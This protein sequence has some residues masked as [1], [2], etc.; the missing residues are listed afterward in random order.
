MFLEHQVWTIRY[1][2]I[3]TEYVK[4]WFLL[5]IWAWWSGMRSE[6]P[7]SSWSR[8][9]NVSVHMFLVHMRM[10]VIE[11]QA[12]RN[13]RISSLSGIISRPIWTD[14]P[15]SLISRLWYSIARN[16]QDPDISR[17]TDRISI[18]K[19][20]KVGKSVSVKFKKNL[21]IRIRT[22]YPSSQ[23]MRSEKKSVTQNLHVRKNLIFIC[24]L[25]S[26]QLL[27][28]NYCMAKCLIVQ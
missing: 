1:C 15:N 4:Y 6:N 20:L 26:W 5:S 13:E 22:L 14:M 28:T 12:L 27:E 10:L 25:N 2:Q 23:L 21:A 3:E 24:M 19:F 11:I 9:Y 16:F 7:Y 17:I 18:R 8:F